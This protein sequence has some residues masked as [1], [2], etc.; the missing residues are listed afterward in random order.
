[1]IHSAEWTAPMLQLFDN[2]PGVRDRYGLVRRFGYADFR[3]KL[4]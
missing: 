3:N 1:M 4:S 2:A